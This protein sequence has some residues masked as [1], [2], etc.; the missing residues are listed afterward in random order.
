M[1]SGPERGSTRT[2]RGLSVR[3]RTG[4]AGIAVLGASLVGFALPGPAGAAGVITRASVTTTFHAHPD[5]GNHGDWADDDFTRVASVAY[6]SVDPTLTDCGAAATECFDWAGTITDTGSFYAITGAQSPQ[7]GVTETGSPSGPF[8]GTANVVFHASTDSASTSGVPTSI[9]GAG[10]V[11]TTDWVEQFFPA[12]TTFGAGPDLN[13]W[14]WSYSNPG[15]CENWVDAFNNSDG[16][17]PADGD[18]TGVDQC[19]TTTGTI[20]TFVNHSASCL[21]NS[22]ATWANGNLEQIWTCGARGGEDQNFRLALYNGAEVLQSVAP[23]TVSDSP[24]CVT[25]PAAT[26]QLTI[27]ACTGT[28]GQ[29]VKKEGPI[30]VFTATGDVMDLKASSTVNGNAVIAYPENG[31][32]NQQWSL[33]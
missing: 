23:A 9:T 2:S 16:S 4:V 29:V 12:G 24:W 17:L 1:R 33:P 28:G 19:L 22:N 20:S 7:A 26:G 13:V 5:S 14:S 15:T 18:I 6:V 25:A 32:K 10:P 8:Q 3:M 27:Q 11:S 31:G 21:D 30:Y